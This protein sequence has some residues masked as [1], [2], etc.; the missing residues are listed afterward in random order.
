MLDFLQ[1]LGS[2]LFGAGLNIAGQGISNEQAAERERQA[3]AD[4]YRYGEMSAD[5]A[6]QRTRA[7]YED[8]YGIGAQMRQL[9]E[10]GLSPSMFFGDLPGSVGQT[11]AQGTGTAGISPTSFGVSPMEGANLAL[12]AAQTRNLNADADIKEGKNEMGQAQIAQILADAGL[13]DASAAYTKARQTGQEFD[14]YVNGKTTEFRI[15]ECYAKAEIASHEI[16]TALYK[17]LQ[18]QQECQ[19]FADTY[20]EKIK[21]IKLENIVQTTRN[22]LM[23][24]QIKLND[25]ERNKIDAE[26]NKWGEE[27]AQGWANTYINAF[28]A[29]TEQERNKIL[30]DYFDAQIENLENRLEFDK[31]K[32]NREMRYQW[33]QFIVT[34]IIQSNEMFMEG[35]M[36]LISAGLKSGVLGKGAKITGLQ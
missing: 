11:G 13:K 21:S 18:T 8:L 14:N 32:F 6:D 31:N 10:N 12:I 19:L 20:D 30:D 35:L 28:K 27:I 2:A 22:I 36:N 25:A 26:I 7:L 9:K 23:K 3:R 34:S 33:T 16:K 1:G 4:N 24:S 17:S 5:R 15:S 29:N